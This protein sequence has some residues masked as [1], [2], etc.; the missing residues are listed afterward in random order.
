MVDIAGKDALTRIGAVNSARHSPGRHKQGAYPWLGKL[1][2]VWGQ[3]IPRQPH[4]A[5]ARADDAAQDKLGSHFYM[6]SSLALEGS[7]YPTVYRQIWGWIR[8]APG[9]NDA[10]CQDPT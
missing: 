3:E 5:F 10:E 2:Q 8:A 4:S 6:L 1:D 7:W 9:A